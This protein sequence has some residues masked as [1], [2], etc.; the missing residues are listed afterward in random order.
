MKE[1]RKRADRR[2]GPRRKSILVE[3]WRKAHRWLSVQLAAIVAT[4]GTIYEAVP[5]VQKY[6]DPRVAHWLMVAG[7]IGVILGRIK[8]QK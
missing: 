5:N 8:A 1:K 3:D 6:L 4:L 2:I 7:A